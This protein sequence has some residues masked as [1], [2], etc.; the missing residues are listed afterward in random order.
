MLEDL[1]DKGYRGVSIP[2]PPFSKPP[3]HPPLPSAALP[4]FFFCV[5]SCFENASRAHKRAKKYEILYNNVLTASTLTTLFCGFVIMAEG[6]QPPGLLFK[7]RFLP[8]RR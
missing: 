1:K 3:T 2:P 5:S 6:F 7:K 8:G 4:F